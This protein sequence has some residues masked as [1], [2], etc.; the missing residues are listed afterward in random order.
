MEKIQKFLKKC[1]LEEC[2][3]KEVQDGKEEIL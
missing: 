3:I 1:G 2:E